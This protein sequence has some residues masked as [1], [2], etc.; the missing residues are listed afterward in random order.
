MS[1]S[2]ILVEMLHNESFEDA[3]DTVMSRIAFV[4]NDDIYTLGKQKFIFASLTLNRQ[5][6]RK[7]TIE[8]CGCSVPDRDVIYGVVKITTH[9]IIKVIARKTKTYTPIQELCE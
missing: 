2:G 4:Y 6:D 8:H 9:E 1:D 3:V 7:A 5:S